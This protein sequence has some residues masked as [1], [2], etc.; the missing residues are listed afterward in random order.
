MSSDRA[1]GSALRP[2]EVST[3]E[4]EAQFGDTHAHSLMAQLEEWG[5]E[6]GMIDDA[7]WSSYF[8]YVADSHGRGQAHRVLREVE[9]CLQ[10]D[11]P[12]DEPGLARGVKREE[13]REENANVATKRMEKVRRARGMAAVH[14]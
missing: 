9:L 2:A 13:H 11:H 8:Y 4:L 12:D 10:W 5:N 3:E 6:R 14:I 7:E 1:P